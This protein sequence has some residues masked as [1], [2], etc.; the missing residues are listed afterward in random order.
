MRS[1]IVAAGTS[2][3]IVGSRL[4]IGIGD[5]QPEPRAEP[6][7]VAVSG[8]HKGAF[9]VR[10]HSGNEGSRTMELDASPDHRVQ[11]V[12][13]FGGLPIVLLLAFPPHFLGQLLS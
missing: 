1:W 2:L 13:A 12:F 10:R 9:K 6:M 11:L 4:A 5:H 8:N 7:D 3:A